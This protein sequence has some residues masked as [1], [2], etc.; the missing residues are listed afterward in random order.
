MVS[1]RQ[2]L[3]DILR[4]HNPQLTLD[5][6]RRQRLDTDTGTRQMHEDRRQRLG[7]EPMRHR[8]KQSGAGH[9]FTKKRNKDR[10]SQKTGRNRQDQRKTEDVNRPNKENMKTILHSNIPGSCLI[11]ASCRKHCF[12]LQKKHK[13]FILTK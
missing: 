8:H 12:V 2:Y 11:K 3:T 1:L 9:V 6:A 10:K 5:K 4:F 13:Y 7:V